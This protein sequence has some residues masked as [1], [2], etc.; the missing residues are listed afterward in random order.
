MYVLTVF[1]QAVVLL[2]NHTKTKQ[3][4][5]IVNQTVYRTIGAQIKQLL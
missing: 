3:K 1:C 2:Q 5:L 4:Q